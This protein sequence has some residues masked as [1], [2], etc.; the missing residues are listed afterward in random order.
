MWKLTNLQ[1]RSC[2]LAN[3][4]PIHLHITATNIIH[5]K[6]AHQTTN[7]RWTLHVCT[8]SICRGIISPD[9][10]LQFFSNSLF[11]STI[12]H[13]LLGEKTDI[14]WLDV[15]NLIDNKLNYQSFKRIKEEITLV[16]LI[17]HIF[18]EHVKENTKFI[19]LTQR[20]LNL[21][22]QR[23][24]SKIIGSERNKNKRGKATINL[25]LIW[26]FTRYNGALPG[27]QGSY[28]KS[29]NI[30]T[31]TPLNFYPG[32]TQKS[33]NSITQVTTSPTYN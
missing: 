8:C 3:S 9:F 31:Q 30:W 14:E 16:C 17:Y 18:P 19:W 15:F 11:I 2:I 6:I 1:P 12:P 27:I 23:V 33:I 29:K 5:S 24:W 22:N 7:Q 13:G 10:Q 26:N 28:S 32:Y 21:H 4:Q 25:K 20:P